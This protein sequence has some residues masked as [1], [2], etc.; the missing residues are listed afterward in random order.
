M[1]N[2]L[3]NLCVAL[4]MCSACSNEIEQ[5]LDPQP[6]APKLN[7][8]DSLAI[9]D[10]WKKSDGENWVI[11]WDLKDFH[12]WG[13]AGL[14]LDPAT[15]EYRVVKLQINIPVN[16]DVRGEISPRLGD[17]TELRCFRVSGLGITG[18]IPQSISNLKKIEIFEIQYTD[19]T[20]TLPTCLFSMPNIRE[21]NISANSS[22]TGN[23]P[24]EI[25]NLPHDMVYVAFMHNNLSGKIPS[26]INLNNTLLL[27]NNRFT[28]FPF[29]YCQKGKTAMSMS[30][31]EISGLIPD[32]ILNNEYE[33]SRLKAM[34]LGQKEGFVFE[35]APDNWESD[36]W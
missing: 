6:Q 15:N 20:G 7:V 29:E 4:I 14:Y 23:L 32:S 5:P 30:G 25:L 27:D 22:I 17:L 10:I 31:N 35:N 16:E 34:T 18:E 36:D 21:L 13:G 2:P 9:V 19:V 12:T 1:K 3:L 26:G 11:K 33:L 8:K 28:E 24:R